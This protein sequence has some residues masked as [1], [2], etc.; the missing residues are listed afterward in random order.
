MAANLK[1]LSEA[2]D[3]AAP[4]RRLVAAIRLKKDSIQQDI[5]RDGVSF[6]T[7]DGQRFRVLAKDAR[8]RD[9]EPKA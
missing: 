3:Q 8:V 9:I 2:I 1:N 7:V 4:D 5:R 6:I